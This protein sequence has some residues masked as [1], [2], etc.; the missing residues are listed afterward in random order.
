WFAFRLR[1]KREIARNRYPLFMEMRLEMDKLKPKGFHILLMREGAFQRGGEFILL[2]RHNII[3]K[4]GG[5]GVFPFVKQQVKGVVAF[6]Y[7]ALPVKHGHGNGV[8]L[9]KRIE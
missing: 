8:L 5:Y 2:F 7:H 3:R 1:Q 9:E 4:A 6:G